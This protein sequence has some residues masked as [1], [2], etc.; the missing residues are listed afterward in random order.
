MDTDIHKQD[1]R[2]TYITFS[3]TFV[4]LKWKLKDR[5]TWK[6]T[7]FTDRKTYIQTD[8]QTDRFKKNEVTD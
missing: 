4:A 5:Q 8:R 3:Y 6:V 1:N 2:L 7:V